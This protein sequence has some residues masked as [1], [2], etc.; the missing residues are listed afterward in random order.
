M[1]IGWG[2]AML[3]SIGTAILN[4]LDAF[5]GVTVM[6]SE[7]SSALFGLFFGWMQDTPG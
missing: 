1:M 2:E 7:R 3:N 4:F 6:D 5:N